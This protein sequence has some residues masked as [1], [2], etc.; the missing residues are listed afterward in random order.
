MQPSR[1]HTRADDAAGGDGSAGRFLTEILMQTR[2]DDTEDDFARIERLRK[3]NNK[4]MTADPDRWLIHGKDRRMLPTMKDVMRAMPNHIARSS[5]FAPVARGRR[6]VL[7]NVVL[8]SRE[9]ARIVFRGKQLDESH[10]DIWMQVMKEATR[11]PLGTSFPMS[12]SRF[13]KAIGRNHSGASYHWLMQAIKDLTFAM[14]VVE[15]FDKQG[16]SRLSI[17]QATAFHMISSF[18]Y[19]DE[20][21]EYR[22][23]IDPRW[24]EMYANNEFALIDWNKRLQFK[25]GQDKAK[26]LQRLIATSTNPVQRYSLEWLKLKMGHESPDRKF[27]EALASACTE[28]QRLKILTAWKIE[29]STR[30]N[31]QLVLIQRESIRLIEAAIEPEQLALEEV[32]D[33]FG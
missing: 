23:T 17:G 8:H 25:R 2:A 26:T 11:Q 21:E 30:G 22:I 28:L 4:R 6:K 16:Q 7:D 12:R 29:M 18:C 19:S 14:L 31:P 27:R 5:L 20:S 32:N 3:L 10:A 13:L 1:L 24:L 15:V 33:G 9:D